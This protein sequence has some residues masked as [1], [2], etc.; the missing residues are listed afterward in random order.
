MAN[1]KIKTDFKDGEKLYANELN[2]NFETISTALRNGGLIVTPTLKVGKVEKTEEPSASIG[3]TSPNFVL[4]IGLPKGDRGPEGQQGIQGPKGDTGIQGPKGDTG[5]Q[6]PKGDTGPQGPEGP[7][8]I[9]G[10]QGPTGPQGPQGEIGPQGP[11][12][13]IGPQGPKGNDG[14]G[15]TILGSYDSIDDLNREHPIG[16]K[17][18]SYIINGAL[19]VWS[20]TEN[21][22]KNVG[23]IQGPQGIQGIQ[24]PTGPQGPKGD[25][26]P[27]GP[28]GDTGA[29][30]IQGPK[31]DTGPEGPKGDTGPQGP[32]GPQGIQGTVG[33]QG[34]KGDKGDKGDTGEQGPQGIQGI[35]GEI[36]PQGPQGDPG[37]VVWQDGTVI[38]F[39]R[40]ITTDIEQLPILDGAIIYDIQKGRNYIDYNDERI[41]VGSAGNEVVIGEESEITED[42]KLIIE[43]DFIDNIGSEVVNSLEG[44]ETNKAPSVKVVNEALA[45][46]KEVYANDEFVIGTW[47]D[48]KPIYRKVIEFTIGAEK[49]SNNIYVGNFDTI[50]RAE[51]F[52]KNASNQSWT[53]PQVYEDSSTKAIWLM[54]DTPNGNIVEQH[55][56][57]YPTGKDAFIIVEYTKTTD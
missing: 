55:N 37:E 33:P 18:D 54:F 42:T 30:G 11:Q 10:I 19:Y 3:G 5:I 34:P 24:G 45:A 7:Q 51:G 21:S 56:Y 53:I 27:E 29:Q 32:E 47:L 6:G 22:W 43:Q 28:K 35:Q 9:Q 38:Q 52:F 57:A 44:N 31:G 4:N 23:N 13:E 40:H 17:G 20:A 46:K 1:I 39:I 26:G 41:Q 15:V 14:S 16:E 48:G 2:A 36:G 25:T 49:T 50:I 8:G 12:G